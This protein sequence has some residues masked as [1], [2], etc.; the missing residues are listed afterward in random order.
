MA[1]SD[2]TRLLGLSPRQ[3]LEPE[4]EEDESQNT[5]QLAS[6]P[7]KHVTLDS[8]MRFMVEFRL[9]C[10]WLIA[11]PNYIFNLLRLFVRPDLPADVML[12]LFAMGD[13]DKSGKLTIDVFCKLLPLAEVKYKLKKVRLADVKD[14]G[15]TWLKKQLKQRKLSCMCFIQTCLKV[16]DKNFVT[17]MNDP[18]WNQFPKLIQL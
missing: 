15:H 6:G 10:C 17:K 9:L 3:T 11:L 4:S 1:V 13:P 8:W 16:W 14:P 12:S 18:E 2:T 7:R 5:S